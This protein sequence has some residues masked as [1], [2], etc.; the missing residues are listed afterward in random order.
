MTSLPFL[1]YLPLLLLLPQLSHPG[2]TPEPK[3]NLTLNM[4]PEPSSTYIV[5]VHHLAKPSHFATLGHWYTS[6]VATHSPLPVADHSTRI[7]Y[8]YD[9]VM[10]GF[11]VQLTGNEARRMSDAEGVSGVHED[12]KL[13]YKTTRSPGFLGLDPAFGAWQDTD[14]GDGVI[15]GIVDSGIWPESQSFNDSGLGP[16]RPSWRGKCV[17]TADFN[18][19]LCNNKLVG[20]KAFT[21]GPFNLRDGYGHGTHVASTAAGSEVRDAGFIM[22]ARGTARGVAPKAKIA[23]YSAGIVPSMSA[24]T[25]A[26]DA[27]VK[28]GVDILSVSIGNPAPL[29][30]YNDTVSIAAFGAERAG[31]FVVF[32]GGNDGPKAS[33]VDNS[34]PWM[35]T[36]GAGTVDRVFPASLHLGDGTVLTGQSI[37]TM[38]ANR[39]NVVPLVIKRCSKKTLTPD[40]I[41]GKIVV[42]IFSLEDKHE[43]QDGVGI[44]VEILQRAGAVGLVQVAMPC[45][46]PDDTYADIAQGAN[47]PG[48]GL[49]YTSAKKLRAYTA[50]EPYPVASLSFS[51][52]TVINENRAPMVATFSSRGPNPFAPELLKPDVIAPGVNI[53][54][55]WPANDPRLPKF[56]NTSYR[57]NFGTSMA[58]PHV[59]GV[60]ALIKKKHSDWT[61]AMIRSAI[62]TTAA[63]LDNTGREILD[64]GLVDSSDNA[65][66]SAATPFAAGAGHVRPQLAM[67]PG[68]VYDSGARDYV[69][70]LCAL[71]YTTEQLRLFAPDMAT[72]TRELPGGGAGLNYPSFVVI[73][74]GRTDV[75]TP[76]RTV[77]KV[78]QEPERYE[79]TVAAPEHVKVTVTPAILEFKEQYEKKSYTVEFRSQATS[80]EPEWEFGHIIWEN[81]K[82]RVRRLRSPIAFT[83]KTNN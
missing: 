30:F 44:I 64:N 52:D 76:T 57:L 48:L 11:A 13:H 45:W 75:R 71:N 77:T 72:C 41:K 65:K 40:H 51:C 31:V 19:S 5:H 61:Q 83:W 79:V 60:A 69:D 3:Q 46:S 27:A 10:H 63:T 38:K 24:T 1:L 21:A 50:S 28:D 73:F 4:K 68:L 74:D 20:A 42:C 66:V 7:L 49:S 22:F 35:T 8:T 53:L 39:A 29:P 36:V 55:A 80:P 67:D 82:R 47:F 15:I 23:M 17:G 18:A 6:M 33:T 26:I 43:D 54:A 70:F 78:S 2:A 25:A 34:A 62:I 32:G 58:T 81:E 37:Y 12:R 14:F 59:A 56:F 16:V 9:T